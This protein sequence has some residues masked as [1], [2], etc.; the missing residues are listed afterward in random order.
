M[1]DHTPDPSAPL[2]PHVEVSLW[3]TLNFTSW[4][5]KS[6]GATHCHIIPLTIVLSKHVTPSQLALATS[7]LDTKAKVLSNLSGGFQQGALKLTERAS[8]SMLAQSPASSSLLLVWLKS[9][10]FHGDKGKWKGRKQT[11]VMLIDVVSLWVSR[12]PVRIKGQ[13]CSISSGGFTWMN[14]LGST[15]RVG[16][17]LEGDG[18]QSKWLRHG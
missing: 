15:M 11:C 5:I 10:T 18:C 16:G 12:A 9:A 3:K 8:R 2:Y 17:T 14:G 13:K 7:P 1:A 4:S 6:I